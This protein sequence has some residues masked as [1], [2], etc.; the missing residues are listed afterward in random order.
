[1]KPTCK[2]CTERT[3]GCHS[4]CKQYAAFIA[5]NEERKNVIYKNRMDESYFLVRKEKLIRQIRRQEMNK[6]ERRP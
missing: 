6:R 4:T 3:L 5:E 2:D 1:M